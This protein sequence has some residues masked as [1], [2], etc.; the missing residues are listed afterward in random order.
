MFENKQVTL[1]LNP[2]DT[3]KC[4]C[5][6]SCLKRNASQ[7]EQ[8]HSHALLLDVLLFWKG[9]HFWFEPQF[10]ILGNTH[11]ALSVAVSSGQYDAAVGHS[12]LT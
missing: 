11:V 7:K 9:S 6:E 12:S 8:E 5:S 1:V 2:T 10:R 3:T 4:E